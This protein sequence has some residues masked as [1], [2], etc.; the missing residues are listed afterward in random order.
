MRRSSIVVVM[1][2]A[3]LWQSLAMARIGSTVNALHDLGHAALHWQ[4]EAHHHLA[5]GSYQVDDSSESTQHVAMD[6]QNVSMALMAASAHDFLRLGAGAPAG[7]H[8]APAPDPALDG[9]LRPPRSTP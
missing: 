5:D 3:L 4:E 8:E 9:L 1:L 2:F 6:H 7:V